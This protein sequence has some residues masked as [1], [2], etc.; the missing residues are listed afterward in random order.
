MEEIK[1]A[2]KQLGVTGRI[3]IVKHDSF[4]VDVYVDGVWFGLW[5]LVKKTFVE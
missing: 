1:E 3:R 4:T 2:L 5:D